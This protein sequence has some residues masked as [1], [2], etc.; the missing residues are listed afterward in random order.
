MK[1]ILFAAVCF[2]LCF[3]SCN[4]D[5]KSGAA[6][7]NTSG[8]ASDNSMT[9]KNLDA[10]HVVDKAFE[11]GDVS[12]IDSAVANDFV[13]HTDRGDMNRDSLKAMIKM[14]HATNKDMKMETIKEL[15]DDEYVFSLMHF[16]GTS[17]G[18]MMPKG[19]YDMQAIEVVKY[20]DGKAVEHWEYMEAGEMM[21]MMEKMQGMNKKMN[22]SNKKK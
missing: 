10:S 18:T 13:D 17:D 21:K 1:T 5:N 6:N 9:Q 12:G 16:T 7:D 14:V 2:A 15:A 4:S 19:P 20:K 22:N 3:T 11:T 8:T